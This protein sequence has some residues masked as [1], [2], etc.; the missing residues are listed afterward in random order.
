[1]N[2]EEGELNIGGE[3]QYV[4][5]M[6]SAIETGEVKSWLA[7]FLA[8]ARLEAV[9]TAEIRGRPPIEQSVGL[10]ALLKFDT[11]PQMKAT[12]RKM[13]AELGQYD[14]WSFDFMKANWIDMHE[15][16]K[17]S[18]QNESTRLV[19]VDGRITFR[20]QRYRISK[21]LRGGYV[22]VSLKN[23]NLNVYHGGVLVKTLKLRS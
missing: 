15:D 22:E 1:M 16:M 17:A 21:R 10:V 12:M 2:Y 19:N 14:K 8:S 11:N 3:K 18:A 13:A 23:G 9:L 4:L 20:G 6:V 5:V 7:D